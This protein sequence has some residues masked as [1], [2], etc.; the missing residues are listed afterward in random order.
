MVGAENMTLDIR[1]KKES[2]SIGQGH[3]IQSG[4]LHAKFYKQ[5]KC[6]YIASKTRKW[7]DT[8]R[9]VKFKAEVCTYNYKI[10]IISRTY[11]VQNPESRS[12]DQKQSQGKAG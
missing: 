5:F 2:L 9:S 11:E 6:H 8:S 10:A 7:V 12:V 3:T 4:S 1:N